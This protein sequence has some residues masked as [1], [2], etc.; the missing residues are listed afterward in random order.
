M[1]VMDGGTMDW[2]AN[3]V[4]S[5]LKFVA[6]CP[7]GD[8]SGVV[9]SPISTFLV[10]V[11]T[12]ADVLLQRL[13]LPD[14]L[15]ILTFNPFAA[16][17]VS[18][19]PD[20]G[21]SDG[22]GDGNMTYDADIIAS[23]K[24]ANNHLTAA[25]AG[26]A[27]AL[28]GAGI[29][30]EHAVAASVQAVGSLYTPT[31]A[32]TAAAAA[33][34]R[35]GSNAS[36]SVSLQ[37]ASVV[38]GIA[39]QL[40][41]LLVAD[42]D[43]DYSADEAAR[44]LYA[45]AQA[46]ANVNHVIAS[47]AQGVESSAGAV[48]NIAVLQAQIR[49]AAV[50]VQNADISDEAVLPFS[51]S[52]DEVWQSTVN[53]APTDIVL[54]GTTIDI[55]APDASFGTASAV[56]DFTVAGNFVYSVEGEQAAI[57]SIGE[58]DGAVRFASSADD[59]V[60]GNSFDIIIVAKDDGHKAFAKSFVVDVGGV[61]A[62]TEPNAAPEVTLVDQLGLG[63]LVGIIVA[64][65]VVIVA[66]IVVVVLTAAAKKK[67]KQQEAKHPGKRAGGDEENV[68]PAR[69]G[70][71][72]NA[73]NNAG[74]SAKP[75]VGPAE[76]AAAAAGGAGES[77]GG[78]GLGFRFAEAPL[79]EPLMAGAGR[80]DQKQPKPK[81]AK[82][83]KKKKKK[84]SSKHN[85]PTSGPNVEA[86]A[87]AAA[88]AAVDDDNA[89]SSRRDFAYGTGA[90]TGD[91]TSGSA[92]TVDVFF[93]DDEKKREEA[94]QLTR[95]VRFLNQSL[96]TPAGRRTLQNI[97]DLYYNGNTRKAHA[98]L[99]YKLQNEVKTAQSEVDST[100]DDEQ[101]VHGHGG[102]GGGGGGS[103]RGGSGGG[104]GSESGSEWDG[105]SS[106][107]R[108]RSGGGGGSGSS[109]RHGGSTGGST[110]ASS[111]GEFLQPTPA[112]EQFVDE[113]VHVMDEVIDE[114]SS[115]NVEHF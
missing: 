77:G 66:V 34:G 95:S 112:T 28:A 59:I 78:P 26:F 82:K 93:D 81:K 42:N 17:P 31:A 80:Q 111:D 89:G 56:D 67:K 39:V 91:D 36:P 108:R 69:N 53:L 75:A 22:V 38:D 83:K 11:N 98:Y 46:I 114:L 43:K 47:D 65:V 115:S 20:G 29:E 63:G 37:N 27:A 10:S 58:R 61:L 18:A 88:A 9:V 102:S 84:A 107:R 70:G 19:T 92:S 14:W 64:I 49:Q 45:T 62:T 97:A 86:A 55:A 96:S 13:G 12:T 24:L 54:N 16:V 52:V 57:F 30:E 76:A 23:V 25:V 41:P 99:V 71:I 5:G 110:G 105:A 15:E 87:T 101:G 51:V 2:Q 35:N 3:A 6:P 94:W 79:A 21:D 50:D 109:R 85:T 90:S 68:K 113:L 8:C 104:G 72:K 7:S 100:T 4:L 1:G 32:A 33:D 106:Q 103:G 48:S 73:D 60:V 40:L 44:L 74:R